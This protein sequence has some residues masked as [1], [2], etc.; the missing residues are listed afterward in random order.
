[1][2]HIYLMSQDWESIWNAWKQQV[3]VVVAVAVAEVLVSVPMVVIV[4]MLATTMLD[5]DR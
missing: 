5:D 3:V 4:V 2:L 1:M